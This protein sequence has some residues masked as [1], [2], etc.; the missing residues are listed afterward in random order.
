[1][2]KVNLRVSTLQVY[3][4]RPMRIGLGSVGDDAEFQL[5]VMYDCGT[6]T[7]G[8]DSRACYTSQDSQ[9]L[10]VLNGKTEHLRYLNLQHLLYMQFYL[11][12]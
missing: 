10:F 9:P 7:E 1:M 3:C 6:T 12:W 8:F 2:D 4:T 5:R 11:A